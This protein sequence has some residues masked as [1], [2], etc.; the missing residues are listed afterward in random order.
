MIKLF[1][2]KECKKI[3][4]FTINKEWELYNN[5]FKYYQIYIDEAWLNSKIKYNLEINKNINNIEIIN[6][7]II[8][9]PKN[10]SLPTHT[11]NYSN[12]L[13]ILKNTSFTLV[14]FLNENYIGGDFYFNNIE[15][16][17]FNGF[18]VIHDRSTTQRIK[19]IIDGDCFLLFSHIENK[20]HNKLI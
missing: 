13:T 1:S 11:F 14:S 20:K 17:V 19:K 12:Y 8:K 6:T 9:L 10:F 7:R 5:D 4:D 15:N 18:G 2:N 3:L 16:K